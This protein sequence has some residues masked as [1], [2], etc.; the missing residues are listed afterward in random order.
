MEKMLDTVTL[1]V[2]GE[3]DWK[4]GGCFFSA[5]D[6]RPVKNMLIYTFWWN[7]VVW[8]DLADLDVGIIPAG[9]GLCVG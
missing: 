6:A 7:T 8:K 5:R 4:R 2:E 3:R 1:R 9:C